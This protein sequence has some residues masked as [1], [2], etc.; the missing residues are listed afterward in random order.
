MENKIENFIKI[1][2]FSTETGGLETLL[3]NRAAEVQ[4]SLNGPNKKKNKKKW[5]KNFD[6]DRFQSLDTTCCELDIIITQLRLGICRFDKKI[7]SFRSLLINNWS[8][9]ELEDAFFSFD[10]KVWIVGAAFDVNTG[11]A[12]DF[13]AII[14]EQ[15]DV[16]SNFEQRLISTIN[17]SPEQLAQRLLN[18][19]EVA[20]SRYKIFKRSKVE[21]DHL[22]NK[23]REY[24]IRITN[25]RYDGFL[26]RYIL[27]YK[28]EKED[29][30]EICVLNMEA[31]KRKESD[32]HFDIIT[33]QLEA[34]F[35]AMLLDP[36]MATVENKEIHDKK[37]LQLISEEDYTAFIE[38][39]EKLDTAEFCKRIET[40]AE[41]MATKQWFSCPID[42]LPKTYATTDE[43]Y[44]LL[45]ASQYRYLGALR[46]KR[47]E[48]EL[49]KLRSRTWNQ[50][51]GRDNE[52]KPC[53]GR[54]ELQLQRY[55]LLNRTNKASTTINRDP[56]ILGLRDLEFQPTRI[57]SL[58][59]L[60]KLFTDRSMTEKS[61]KQ[62]EQAFRCLWNVMMRNRIHEY[63]EVFKPIPFTEELITE[64]ELKKKIKKRNCPPVVV[65][66]KNR[67]GASCLLTQMLKYEKK[68]SR[69]RKIMENKEYL[70]DVDRTKRQRLAEWETGVQKKVEELANEQNDN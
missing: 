28:Y 67:D 37:T 11:I 24:D 43:P 57:G 38:E 7:T 30:E 34:F 51:T 32:F 66:S 19:E 6:A 42:I 9:G 56:K 35:M 70:L 45:S 50:M 26:P 59:W 8:R 44:Q 39:M 61:Q 10:G 12:R 54:E 22:I 5:G 23:I 46:K 62:L 3:R 55:W 40:I 52:G 69:K 17:D 21:E 16:Q 63:F 68:S 14:K 41:F 20:Y 2:Q 36:S 47:S 58:E 4:R 15:Q 25:V 18:S 29:N 65:C 1:T 27:E 53:Y 49:Q 13:S 33:L 64:A 60:L 31:P 48:L